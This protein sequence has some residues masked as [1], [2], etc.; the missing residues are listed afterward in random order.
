VILSCATALVFVAGTGPDYKASPAL[1]QKIFP[2]K[3]MRRCI[4]AG[5]EERKS[6]RE[7]VGKSRQIVTIGRF[8]CKRD[9]YRPGRHVESHQISRYDPGRRAMAG[10]N[11]KRAARTDTNLAW[12]ST[13]IR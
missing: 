10:A 5:G 9:A 1:V 8:F 6:N 4:F 11:V 3:T 12:K 13:I 7:L 2:S